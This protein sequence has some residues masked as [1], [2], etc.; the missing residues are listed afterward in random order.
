MFLKSGIDLLPHDLSEDLVPVDDAAFDAIVFCE[1]LEHLNFNPLP[2]IGENP[3]T[4][5]D[6]ILCDA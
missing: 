5:R 4:K 1:V 6:R 2:F 3:V